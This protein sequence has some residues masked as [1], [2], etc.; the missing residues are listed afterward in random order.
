MN[1]VSD[2]AHDVIPS[3]DLALQ[4]SSSLTLGILYTDTNVYVSF[5]LLFSNICIASDNPFGLNQ[6]VF[7]FGTGK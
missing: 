4:V 3:G 7:V 5:I 6:T 2:C 1:D